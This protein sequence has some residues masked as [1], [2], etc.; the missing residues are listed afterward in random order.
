MVIDGEVGT[1][2]WLCLVCCLGFDFVGEIVFE[3]HLSL[4]PFVRSFLL[5]SV[6]ISDLLKVH[7]VLQFLDMRASC[8]VSFPPQDKK[9]GW[10][11]LAFATVL[12]FFITLFALIQK[13]VDDRIILDV[14]FIFFIINW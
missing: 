14:V 7:T 2:C 1:L 5:S 3:V 10:M 4:T 13:W 8:F 11:H 12:R 9:I 6:M